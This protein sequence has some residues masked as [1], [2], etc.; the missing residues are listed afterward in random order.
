MDRL[1]RSP[2]TMASHMQARMRFARARARSDRMCCVPP[3]AVTTD[4]DEASEGTE[5][6]DEACGKRGAS[7]R[8][9]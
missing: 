2:S 1:R 4:F 9:A 5:D 3:W 7:P 6:G 8:R